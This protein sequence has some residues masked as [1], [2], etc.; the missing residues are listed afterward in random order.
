M[1]KTIVCAI[2]LGVSLM[3]LPGCHRHSKKDKSTTGEA[4]PVAAP[5]AQPT[6]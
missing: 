4:Q 5:A 2:I 3:L 1:R 6:K